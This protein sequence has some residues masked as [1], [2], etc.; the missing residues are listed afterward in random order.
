MITD[1]TIPALLLISLLI[2]PSVLFTFF[3]SCIVLLFFL[4]FHI[5]YRFTIPFSC[6]QRF[7]IVFFFFF[8]FYRFLSPTWRGPAFSRVEPLPKASYKNRSRLDPI[9]H[10]GVLFLFFSHFLTFS[11]S[12][13]LYFLYFSLF[14]YLFRSPFRYT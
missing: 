11:L 9:S 14:R 12:Y 8:F 6:L 10:V 4:L 2:Y 7:F 13:F 3:F 1:T 5:F